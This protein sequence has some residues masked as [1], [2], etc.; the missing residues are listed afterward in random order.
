MVT[1]GFRPMTG[2]SQPILITDRAAARRIGVSARMVRLWV[3]TRA[4]PLPRSC[5]G[6]SWLFDIS[7]VDHWLKTG[8]WPAGVRF[9]H[10]MPAVVHLTHSRHDTCDGSPRE[11][12][13][14]SCSAVS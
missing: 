3:H 12:E 8:I 2:Q 13:I 6:D 14:V 1:N 10:S 7:D 5:Q 4:W 9:R 11:K